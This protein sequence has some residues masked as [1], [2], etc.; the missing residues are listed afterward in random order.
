MDRRNQLF[1]HIGQRWLSRSAWNCNRRKLGRRILL[2]D[3]GYQ[4]VQQAAA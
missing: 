1:A 3:D 2:T 4:P